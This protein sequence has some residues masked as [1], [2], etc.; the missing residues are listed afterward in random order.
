MCGRPHHPQRLP[1]LCPVDGRNRCYD[2]RI[3]LALA[4]LENEQLQKKIDEL[5]TPV[6]SDES[7]QPHGLP[8]N[9]TM[10]VNMSL[11]DQRAAEDRTSR[12]IEQ[13]EKLRE[14]VARARKDIENRKAVIARRK[15][16]LASASVGFEARRT[17]IM[18]ETQRSIS[19]TKFKW[20]RN[21][22]AL[23]R[24][25]AFLCMEAAKLY[26]L[27]RTKKNGSSTKYEYRLGNVEIVDLESIQC[28]L[29]SPFG[30]LSCGCLR[31]DD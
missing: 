11:S 10:A 3:K 19:A 25:R 30:S 4:H 8:Q 16:D 18:D 17:R 5:V 9:R 2:A 22:D 31:A 20:D 7:G 13:A 12:I 29:S 6:S 27:R 15:A 28:E 21:D 1:F 23:A 26:G 14:E 24:T